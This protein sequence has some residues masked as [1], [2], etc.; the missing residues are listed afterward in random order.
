M[1]NN[2][3]HQPCGIVKIRCPKCHGQLSKE[4]DFFGVYLECLQCGFTKDLKR[5]E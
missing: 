5:G 3:V 2:S 1:N 4:S